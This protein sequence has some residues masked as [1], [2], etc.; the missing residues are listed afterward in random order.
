MIA[1]SGDRVP[2]R[3]QLQ[4]KGYEKR[5]AQMAEYASA[6]EALD[7]AERER[8]EALNGALVIESEPGR[9]TEFLVY[10]PRSAGEVEPLAPET[11]TEASATAPTDGDGA[12]AYDDLYAD[13]LFLPRSSLPSAEKRLAETPG[14][15][16]ESI[17]IAHS[18]CMLSALVSP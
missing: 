18:R 4:S 2:V 15:A 9:G 10:L 14:V 3:V 12:T 8:A 17:Q 7:A 1:F 16:V 5:A 13:V 6:V 11:A